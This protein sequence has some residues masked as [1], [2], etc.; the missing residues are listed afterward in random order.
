[1][2]AILAPNIIDN[3]DLEIID[4]KLIKDA[5]ES[6]YFSYDGNSMAQNQIGIV[7]RKIIKLLKTL[8]D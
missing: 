8:E 6:Y 7:E 5:L 3:F 2:K 1:M 4:I